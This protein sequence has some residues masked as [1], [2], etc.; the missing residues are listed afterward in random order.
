[1][2]LIY[3]AS[4]VDWLHRNEFVE[5]DMQ[6]VTIEKPV[7]LRPIAK[8][9]PVIALE[10]GGPIAKRIDMTNEE[11]HSDRTAVSSSGLKELL[12]SP[13]HFQHYLNGERQER[14]VF[15]LGTAIHAALLEP[16]RFAAEYLIAPDKGRSKDSKAAYEEFIKQHPGAYFISQSE[17]DMINGIAEQVSKH[18]YASELLK[19]GVAEQSFFWTDEETGILC[20]CRA[21]LLAAPFAILD[22]KSMED[23]SRESFSRSC[24]NYNYDLSAAMYQ[25][26]IEIVTGESLEFAFLAV[27]KKAPHGAALYRASEEFLE[28]GRARFRRALRILQDCR[29]AN[30]FP[31]YQP[32]GS[33]ED[34]DLPR[35]YK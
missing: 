19:L 30:F 4:A 32:G 8:V 35:W 20:K 1:M 29:D 18:S 23:A 14:E 17:M 5:K 24:A 2:V 6:A 10:S 34:I 26:G 16:D 9:A 27:E 22:V 13:M 15:R 25:E 12:R 3:R 31:S 11:Y 28:K 33:F 21:D 7:N